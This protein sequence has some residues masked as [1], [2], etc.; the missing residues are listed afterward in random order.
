M[1]HRVALNIYNKPWLIEPQSAINLLSLWEQ[2][3]SKQATWE[4]ESGEQRAG[5]Q[6][7]QK[8]FQK[9]EIVFAPDNIWDARNFK[10]FDG[11][12]VAIIPVTSVLMK[13][14][15]CGSFGTA[16]LAG[17]VALA[18]N[19]TSVKT[20]ALLI[21]SPG[22]TVD[23]TSAFAETIRSA[24]KQTVAIIDGMA[25][26]AAYWI[27]SAAN[28]V[29]ATSKTDAAGSIGTMVSWYDNSEYLK[30]QYGIVRREYY[31]TKSVDK[32]R[33]F[34]EANE[35]DGK[36][37]IEEML[38]PANNEFIAGVKAGRGEK[39]NTEKEDVFTGKM[40][41]AAQA[42]QYGLIDGIMPFNKI[43]QRSIDRAKT[44]R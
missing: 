1:I 4:D 22:G 2:I 25:A 34:K 31:T 21:D 37:L 3:L 11:A 27:A 38:D 39:I 33:A 10:G 15:Y 28:E 36:M 16:R 13:N 44:I 5:Y 24:K 40:Y 6:N 19:T 42:K 35:G 12:T 20:I 30:N 43:I 9:S 8:L 17:L 7:L 32:N 29:Y 26:S 14:D 41:H 18:D 23:G